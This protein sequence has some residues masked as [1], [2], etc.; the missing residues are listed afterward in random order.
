MAWPL[1]DNRSIPISRGADHKR[2][3]NDVANVLSGE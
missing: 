2:G 3:G 1:E